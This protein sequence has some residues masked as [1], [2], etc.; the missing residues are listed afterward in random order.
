MLTKL[1]FNIVNNNTEY[2]N[3]ITKIRPS[4]LVAVVSTINILF[5]FNSF[6]QNVTKRYV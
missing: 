2:K 4:K 6:R 3:Y 1:T 5:F